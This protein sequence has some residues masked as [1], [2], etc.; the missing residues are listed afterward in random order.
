MLN[1]SSK[2]NTPTIP[3]HAL[4]FH[5]EKSHYTHYI[6]PYL[7]NRRGLLDAHVHLTLCEQGK[8]NASR[9]KN[10]IG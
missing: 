3:Q 7:V 6:R 9:L 8:S 5:W 10:V 4:F 2:M 1:D